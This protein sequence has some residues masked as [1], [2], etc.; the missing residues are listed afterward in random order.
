M[1][2]KSTPSLYRMNFDANPHFLFFKV[3][4]E[5]H[6]EEMQKQLCLLSKHCSL[7]V[8]SGV[9]GSVDVD[10]TFILSVFQSFAV[11]FIFVKRVCWSD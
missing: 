10:S 11:L 8:A 5:L 3:F 2:F 7:F 1:A 6:F 4:L 9:D